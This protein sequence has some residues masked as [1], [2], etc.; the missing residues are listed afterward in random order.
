MVSIPRIVTGFVCSMTLV[1]IVLISFAAHLGGWLHGDELAF[2]V[3]Q[4]GTG[5]R[6]ESVDL[7]TGVRWQ[8]MTNVTWSKPAWSPDGS[9]LAFISRDSE[10][11]AIDVLDVTTGVVHR[12]MTHEWSVDGLSWSPDGMQI[13]FFTY[14]NLSVFRLWAVNVDGSDVHPLT[15]SNSFFPDWAPDGSRLVFQRP[16]GLYVLD[17]ARGQSRRI[18]INVLLA[19]P[20]WSP[21]G[22]RIALAGSLPE[23][24]N[25]RVTS[26]LYTVDP[27]TLDFERITHRTIDCVTA[28]DWS[29][30]S[31]RIAF[32]LNCAN[33]PG[34]YAV[35]ANGSHLQ[36]LVG[37]EDGSFALRPTWRP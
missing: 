21:D 28:P 31:R 11:H 6:I 24:P 32:E 34:I 3:A 14:Y 35:D 5:A 23:T 18:A 10:G 25:S 1:S 7:L 17:M 16:T 20:D 19:Q 4:R 12:V 36:R 22:H 29:P 37:V 13:A 26:S 8:L 9:S 2:L 27:D 33:P 30:D 15:D